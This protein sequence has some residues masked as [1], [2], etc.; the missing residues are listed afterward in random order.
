MRFIW[1]VALTAC[2]A[3]LP[4]SANDVLAP[5]PNFTTL[6]AP[7]GAFAGTWTGDGRTLTLAENGQQVTG[8]I[9]VAGLTGTV[10]ALIETGKLVGNF[11]LGSSSN[12]FTATLE[13]ERL[14][15]AVEGGLAQPLTHALAA[16]PAAATAACYKRQ[17][18]DRLKNEVTYETLKLDGAG[19]FTLDTSVTNTWG[20][21]ATFRVAH[22]V[23][24]YV[25]DGQT[26]RVT[27]K[28]GKTAT[29]ALAEYKR[30]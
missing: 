6:S 11:T 10:Q 19:N 26:L 16:A 23:G 20:D 5:T 29:F 17:T 14:M 4:S 27:W 1:V 13:G 28:T 21:S 9:A 25:L 2:G 30:C 15:L 24:N 8:T 12:R 7:A 3:Q 22:A 18:S